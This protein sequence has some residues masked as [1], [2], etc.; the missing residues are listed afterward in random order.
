LNVAK[1]DVIKNPFPVP[2]RKCFK[3]KPKHVLYFVDYAGLQMRLIA[4][5]CGE[6]EMI[7][8]INKNGDIHELATELFYSGLEKPKILKK[9][10]SK[11]EWKKYRNAGKNTHFAIPFG[12][13]VKQASKTLNLPLDIAYIG[14]E[15]YCLR[16]PK[17]AYYSKFQIEQVRRFGYVLT[18]F[19][20]KL[21]VP[22]DKAYIGANY[23]IQGA[24]AGLMKRALIR[25]NK[26]F[27]KEWN[28]RLKLVLDI[29]DEVIFSCPVDLVKYESEY[30]KNVST[31][32]TDIKEIKVRLDVEWK[33][34]ESTWYNAKEIN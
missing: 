7:G 27:E 6:E 26:Y 18:P 11:R 10:L 25:V 23:Y 31:L 33:K 8:I 30:I 13:G 2:A 24:E 32:M 4:D 28:D 14:V 1:E 34:S 3:C 5:S 22:Q 16:Y 29:Y 12:A 9:L 19:G 21:Y 20:R 17:V 15:T